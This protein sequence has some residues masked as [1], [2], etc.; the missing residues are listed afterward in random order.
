MTLIQCSECGKQVSDK[1]QGCPNCGAPIAAAPQ[2]APPPT[3]QQPTKD[4]K[5]KSST[6]Q[7]GCLGCLGVFVILLAIVVLIPSSESG[8]RDHSTMAVVQCRNFVRD[9]LQSPSTADFPFLDHVVSAVGNETFVVRSHVD[10]QN[11]FG[12]TIRNNYVCRIQYSG[13]DDADQ[14]NWNLIDL[15]L[16]P[17]R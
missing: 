16:G 11:A 8:P 5:K 17:V 10:A 15:Q 6:A 2:S 7:Q 9:R 4:D 1:A 14:R 13:G 12:A 3:P